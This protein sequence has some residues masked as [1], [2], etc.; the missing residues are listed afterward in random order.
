[1]DLIQINQN[2][3]GFPIR[4]INI[5]NIINSVNQII[6]SLHAVGDKFRIIVCK[7]ITN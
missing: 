7:A 6:K 2:V 5:R 4:A 3:G 1:M